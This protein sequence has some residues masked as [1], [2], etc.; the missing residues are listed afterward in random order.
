MPRTTVPSRYKDVLPRHA[1]EIYTK[2][3]NSAYKEYEDKSKRRGDESREATASK[4][5]WKAVSTRYE[6]GEDGKWHPKRSRR[7]ASTRR[8]RAA[9]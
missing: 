4:V 9:S 2:V 7:S 8:T 1:Q 5:A 3:F 6:K